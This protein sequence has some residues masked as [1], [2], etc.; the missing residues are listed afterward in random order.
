MCNVCNTGVYGRSGCAYSSNGTASGTPVVN[1]GCS[2]GCWNGGW[3]RVCRDACGN[4][5]VRNVNCCCN[6]NASC[7]CGNCGCS[8]NGNASSSTGSN[9]NCNQN[10][11]QNGNG[12]FRCVTFCG[13]GNNSVQTR[14]NSGCGWASYYARQ[15]GLTCDDNAECAY[16]FSNTQL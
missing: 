13:Y 10:C 8:G 5:V 1:N 3:Q 14:S 4:I 15:Y 11:N 12:F 7:G 9:Q 2:C 6:Q 16:N